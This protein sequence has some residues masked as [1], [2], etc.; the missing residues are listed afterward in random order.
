[1]LN[2]I[3]IK[4][5]NKIHFHFRNVYDDEMMEDILSSK[6]LFKGFNKE[7]YQK[8]L[9][10]FVPKHLCIYLTTQQEDHFK[11]KEILKVKHYG[12]EYVKE[13]FSDSLLNLMTNPDVPTSEHMKLSN[14]PP[15]TFFPKSLD[16]LPEN[17]EESKTVRNIYSDERVD[18]FYK[19]SDKFKNPKV[20]VMS[21]FYT[22]D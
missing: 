7:E 5:L 20:N 18:L 19:K 16:I 11:D 13:K 10:G 17:L 6:Y 22:N 14:P 2:F 21:L 12:T 1:M 3:L 9:N 4:L 15:N 8:V